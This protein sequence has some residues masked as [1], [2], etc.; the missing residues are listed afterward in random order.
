MYKKTAQYIVGIILLM[1]GVIFTT[2]LVA[3]PIYD[4]T[5]YINKNSVNRSIFIPMTILYQNM[6]LP[7]GPDTI[8]TLFLTQYAQKLPYSKIPYILDIEAWNVRPNVS[9]YEANLYIDKY[10]LVIKTLKEARP[11]LKFGYYG[12]LPT[13]DYVSQ[14]P[15]RGMKYQKWYHSNERLKRLAEYVDVI[16]PDLYTHFNDVKTWKQYATAAILE[17]RRYGKPVYPFIWPEYH[18]ANQQ[19]K[20][21][22]ID[23]QFWEQQLLLLNQMADGTIVWGGRDFT[24]K[25]TLSRIWNEN[26]P[27]WAVTK[28]FILKR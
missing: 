26:D 1:Q 22:Y 3:K 8:D 16:C 6:L 11:D 12:T 10:I 2:D 21:T 28:S 18:D 19:L 13:R 7:K 5:G 17:A 27:W 9:D 25:P 4:T 14:D 24:V 15:A 20:G 23:P